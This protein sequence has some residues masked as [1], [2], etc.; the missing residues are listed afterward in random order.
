MN[1]LDDVIAAIA[2]PV[3]EGGISVIRVSG[4]DAIETVSGLFRGR[5]PLTEVPAQTAH[6]GHIVDTGGE[7]VDEAVATVFRAPH[8]YTAEDTVEISCHGGLYL[9]RRILDLILGG[10][11]R[12]AEP[13]EFTKRAFLNGRIDLAQAEAV[14]DIIRSR[15]ETAHRASLAQLQGRLSD[16]IKGLRG[17]L[18]DLCGLIELELDFAEEGLEFTRPEDLAVKINKVREYIRELQD[19]YRYGRQY[20]EGVKVVLAGRPNVGK[21]SILNALL[22]ENRAI[23]TEIPGTTRDVIEE[24]ITI[25]G[26]LFSI[27]DT[28]GL[29]KST[30]VIE[31]EGIL[32]AEKELSD[33]DIVI[34]VIDATDASDEDLKLLHA[35]RG[36]YPENREVVVAVNKIDKV[37]EGGPPLPGGLSGFSVV[38]TS[39]LKEYGI[40]D[41]R[42]ILFERSH[43]TAGATQEASVVITNSRHFECLEGAQKDLGEAIRDL[44][45]KRSNELIA[46]SLRSALDH[47]GEIVGFITN[48]E[49]LEHIFSSFCIGK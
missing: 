22:K 4:A 28:A 5:R 6:F 13:G 12:R 19:T 3:G 26:M 16:D 17:N 11:A 2:T 7:I 23:V 18:L 41:L 1:P 45:A 37:Q 35:L 38:R 31:M 40:K 21:S 8:S 43:Q 39:A 49:I 36:N 15:T 20:R 30:D 25:E 27:V 46:V 47:L 9:T 32:R 42:D 33:A 44:E 10:G 24:N 14:A 34:F 29:R 48:D